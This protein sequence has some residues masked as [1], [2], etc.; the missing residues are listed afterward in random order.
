[1]PVILRQASF[2]LKAQ[3]QRV[4]PAFAKIRLPRLTYKL[5]HSHTAGGLKNRQSERL[6]RHKRHSRHIIQVTNCNIRLKK[7]LVALFYLH[8]YTVH[9][10]GNTEFLRLR[11]SWIQTLCAMLFHDGDGLFGPS[12]N[13][14][15]PEGQFCRKQNWEPPSGG[16]RRP[17]H[18]MCRVKKQATTPNGVNQR[19]LRQWLK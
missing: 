2:P 14:C 19:L 4:Q 10:K 15:P 12:H 13:M 16:S 8:M 7:I 5:R 3:P 9:N 11:R 1:M 17:R 6:K 18:R